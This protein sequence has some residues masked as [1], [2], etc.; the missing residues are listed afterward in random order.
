VA[1]AQLLLPPLLLLLLL[2]FLL[3]LLLLQPVL[4]SP[5]QVLL[6]G[7]PRVQQPVLLVRQGQESRGPLAGAQRRP[8]F[9]PA[10]RPP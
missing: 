8:G 9:P 10:V 7:L 5:L 1:L 4:L 6:P 2:L 3:L